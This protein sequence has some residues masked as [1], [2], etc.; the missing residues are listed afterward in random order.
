MDIETT[1][2]AY[3]SCLATGWQCDEGVVVGAGVGGYTV[4]R[5]G[6]SVI[7]ICIPPVCPRSQ[8]IAKKQLKQPSSLQLEA[9]VL[10]HRLLPH[11]SA[12]Y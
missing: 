3:N 9:V 7:D 6:C 10:C 2:L 1:L 8:D 4:P 11:L 5:D 12:Q